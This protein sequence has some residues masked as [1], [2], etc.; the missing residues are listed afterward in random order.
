MYGNYLFNYL[1][2]WYMDVLYMM[3]FVLN[4]KNPVEGE[5]MFLKKYI[6]R[7]CTYDCMFGLCK[8]LFQL[9]DK[10]YII[11]SYNHVLI[12]YCSLLAMNDNTFIKSLFGNKKVYMNMILRFIIC[13]PHPQII[14]IHLRIKYFGKR[15]QGYMQKNGKHVR[16][17]LH[18][19]KIR[20]C[21]CTLLCVKLW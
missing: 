9:T 17:K 10:F 16:N 2:I 20:A 15:K 13:K 5:K 1:Y 21:Q 3:K 19:S 14:L 4:I 11:S 6:Y 8:N 18:T 12:K 7:I